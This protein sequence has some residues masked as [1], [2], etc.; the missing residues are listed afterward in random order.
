MTNDI[1]KLSNPSDL[2]ITDMRITVIGDGGWRWP[3][4]KIYTNQDIYGL[5]EVRD[6]ASAKYALSLKSRILGENPCDIDKIFQKIK[7]FGGHGRLGGGVC[8]VEMALCDLAGKAFGVPA[9]MLA[10]GKYRDKVKVY[11][12]TPVKKDPEEMGKALL[13]RVKSGFEFLKM[14]IGLWI[15]ADHKNGVVNKNFID[16][17]ETGEANNIMH[18]FTGIQVTDYGISKMEEYVQTVRDIIGYEIPLASDHFGH[19]GVENAIKIGKS[20]DKFSLAWYED[21]IPWQLVDQ[22]KMLKNRVDTPVCT[23]EDIY[24]KEGFEPLVESRAISVAHPD[25]ATSGGI[26]ETKRIADYCR[27]AGI[28]IALH[29][30]GSPI[31]AMANVHCAASIDNFIA[32]EMHSVDNP[33]WNDLVNLVGQEGPMIKDGYINVTNAPGLGIDINEEAM[34]EHLAQSSYG[35]HGTNNKFSIYPKGYFEDTSD[36][37]EL[38]SHDR[39]WS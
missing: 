36:W 33:W 15:A 6:G 21:M 14:D 39:T 31:V 24:C 35:V 29:Q 25:L 23:G 26:L 1:R 2:K 4:I 11:A 10:G 32:L 8:G 22:W 17:S 18:P 13:E 9:Y 3:I 7:Q 38:D 27:D 19:M 20:L 28:P 5:G 37:D 16:V 12:D 34:K 30:A